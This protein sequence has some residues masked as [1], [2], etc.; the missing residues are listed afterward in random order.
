MSEQQQHMQLLTAQVTGL[1]SSFGQQTSSQPLKELKDEMAT[2]KGLLLN[3]HQ[4]PDMSQG[5]VRTAGVASIPNWQR[6]LGPSTG[7]TTLKSLTGHQQ[8]PSPP[9]EVDGN[10]SL[11]ENET[12]TAASGRNGIEV[13]GDS[14]EEGLEDDRN[15][16]PQALGQGNIPQ[17]DV[18]NV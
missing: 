5:S 9:R 8:E 10:E 7:S 2:L 15:I 3:R 16:H 11:K 1:K 14:D 12:E 13:P 17:V 4:F 18:V 6:N